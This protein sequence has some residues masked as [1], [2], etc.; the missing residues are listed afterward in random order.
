VHAVTTAK[1]TQAAVRGTVGLKAVRQAGQVSYRRHLTTKRIAWLMMYKFGWR[2]RH[3]FKYLNRLWMR[4]SSWNVYAS[5]PYSGAYGIPQAVPGWKMVSAGRNWR[6]S[7]RTQIRWGLRYIKSRYGSPAR[8]WWH[9][10][11]TGWY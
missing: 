6:T 7:A 1:V 4:E 3:Q 11:A 5:N 10:A 8:A 2:A 9:E